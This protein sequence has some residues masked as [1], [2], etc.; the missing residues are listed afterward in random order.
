MQMFEEDYHERDKADKRITETRSCW[1]ES[2]IGILTQLSA[3]DLYSSQVKQRI[4][5]YTP[6]KGP[7]SFWCDGK[8]GKTA[9]RENFFYHLARI[10]I[11]R[12]E[13]SKID[14]V[15]KLLNSTFM[16]FNWN[17]Y[18]SSV[19]I[20]FLTLFRPMTVWPVMLPWLC[21]PQSSQNW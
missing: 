14:H 4:A 16:R 12:L 19:V 7:P 3:V 5:D 20:F 8:N 18:P 13:H 6:A 15:T 21:K 2:S 17:I 9:A 11:L 10:S 1:F